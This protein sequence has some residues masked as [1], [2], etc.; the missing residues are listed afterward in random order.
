MSDD[1]PVKSDIDAIIGGA[2]TREPGASAAKASATLEE[3]SERLDLLVADV[4]KWQSYK[5]AST[6]YIAEFTREIEWH[7]KVRLAVCIACGSLVFFLATCLVLGVL[8]AAPLFGADHS[9]ALTALVVAA[10]SGSVV[11]MIAPVRGAFSTLSDRN[12]GLPMPEHV[13]ELVEVGKTMF[14][15]GG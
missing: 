15:K 5:A 6:D 11:V 8:F 3:L 13:K 7:R 9:H 14:G 10:I 12:A 4:G 2:A 1:P